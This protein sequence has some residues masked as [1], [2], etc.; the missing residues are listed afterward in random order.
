MVPCNFASSAVLEWTGGFAWAFKIP[1]GAIL[2]P[3]KRHDIALPAVL[4]AVAGG[5]GS[6]FG[7]M[8]VEFRGLRTSVMSSVRGVE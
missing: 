2:A 4:V 3:T 1:L 8:E 5:D 7:M 6:I